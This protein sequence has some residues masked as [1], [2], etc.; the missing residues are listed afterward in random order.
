MKSW[1]STVI[2]ILSAAFAFILFTPET[3]LAFPWL[4][5]LAKFVLVGGLAGLGIVA[6]DYNVSGGK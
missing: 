6:K 4:I 1:K 5:S 2:G 3:F